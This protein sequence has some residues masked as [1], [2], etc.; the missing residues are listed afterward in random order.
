[1]QEI[2]Q[3]P[4]YGEIIYNE[5]FW[6]GRKSL[7]INGVY[8]KPVSKNEYL[9]NEKKAI[10]NGSFLNGTTLLIDGESIQLTPKIKWYEAV[11]AMIPLFFLITWGNNVFLCSIFPVVGGGI[12]GLLGGAGG[13]LSLFFMKTQKKPILKITIGIIGA[14]ATILIAFLIALAIISNA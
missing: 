4:V 6:S 12:G 3:H 14:I 7:K 8:V 9:I 11:L 13:A 2:I 1:M 5:S 10:I